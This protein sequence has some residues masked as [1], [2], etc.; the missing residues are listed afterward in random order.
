MFSL[1]QK[2]FK[3]C[4][5]SMLNETKENRTKPEPKNPGWI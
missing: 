1:K 5:H 4:F 3:K 2:S